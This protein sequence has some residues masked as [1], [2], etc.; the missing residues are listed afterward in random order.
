MGS[1]AAAAKCKF[2]YTPEFRER[3]VVP[4]LK[5]AAGDA[6]QQWDDPRPITG[7]RGQTVSL[8]FWNQSPNVLHA[9]GIRIVV[10]ACGRGDYDV[11]IVS[12]EVVEPPPRRR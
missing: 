1:P 10:K 12:D 7:V 9:D 4:E 5:K 6:W 2:V 8:L 11:Q 3:V